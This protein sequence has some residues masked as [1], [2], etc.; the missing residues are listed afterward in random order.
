MPWPCLRNCR[1]L[2]RRAAENSHPAAPDDAERSAR[3][4]LLSRV[5]QLHGRELSFNNLHDL[6]AARR[7]AREF[8]LPAC[9]I[10]KHANPC[11]VAVGASIEEASTAAPAPA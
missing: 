9:V 5:T 8:T 4:H 10:V 7:L 6:D 1:T 11:G 2:P 3:T